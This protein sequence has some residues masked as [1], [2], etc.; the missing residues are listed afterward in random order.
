MLNSGDKKNWELAS[1]EIYSTV[2]K[3][4]QLGISVV[5]TGSKIITLLTSEG[6][7]V[8]K[9]ANGQIGVIVT[10]FDDIG[11]ITGVARTTE[12]HTGNYVMK[13]ETINDREHHIEFFND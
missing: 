6:F 9:Y 5:A 1:A 3:M 12:V 13:E 10:Q 11:L 2:V 7:Q 4:S 8:R